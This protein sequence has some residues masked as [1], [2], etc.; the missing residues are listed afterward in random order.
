VTGNAPQEKSVS[1]VLTIFNEAESLPALLASIEY[2]SR[3][4]DEVIIVDGGSTDGSV[5]VLREWQDRLPLTVIESPGA[6]ISAGRNI[7]IERASSDV[8]AVTDAGTVL[9]RTWLERLIGPFGDEHAEVDVAAGFFRP[10]TA[11]EFE[12]ALA[13]TTLPD[14]D[15]IDP[16]SFLPSS[17]SVAFRRS[18]FEAGMCYPEWLDYCED[19]VFDLRLRRAGARFRFVPRAAVS[20]RPRPDL[21]SFIKQYYRYARGDGKAGLFW[22]RHLIRYATYLVAAPSFFL[23]R[24][25]VWKLLIILGALGYMRRP[26][27]R[28]WR[29]SDGDI[30]STLRL[31]PLSAI[32][33]GAGDLAKMAGYP[34]GLI[35]RARRYGLRRD[36]R[37]IP[38]R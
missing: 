37:T 4:P 20:F 5:S 17:R 3:L 26:A 12:V 15:E 33:R 25:R 27:E 24:S 34:V 31:M 36:W 1:L 13:A 19:V 30:L 7:G 35:W 8:V 23:V 14:E 18:W 29:R 6:N 32:L 10:Y 22:K 11:S 2:Q 9:D 16:E 28:L 38:E 21:I